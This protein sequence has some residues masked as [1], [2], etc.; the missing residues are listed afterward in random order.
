VNQQRRVLEFAATDQPGNYR[1]QAG[2]QEGVDRGFSVN[3]TADQIRLTRLAPERLKELFGPFEFRLA[4]DT[5]QLDRAVN[6]GRVGRE[7]FPFLILALALVLGLEQVTANRFYGKDAAAI[8][9]G[10]SAG[11]KPLAT[12]H[13]PPATS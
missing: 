10:T 2:G 6:S 5:R 12:R 9:P 11:A 8:N 7:L 3:L 1:V 4:R 13:P